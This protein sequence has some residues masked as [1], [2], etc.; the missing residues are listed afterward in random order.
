MPVFRE[1]S[2]LLASFRRGDPATLAVVYRAYSAPVERYLNGLAR[3]LSY[4][5]C[6]AS[7]ADVHQ[8]TF[9]RAFSP[10]ARAAYDATREFGPYLLTIAHNC[11]VS[12]VRHGRRELLSDELNLLESLEAPPAQESPRDPRV[13]ELL[14]AYVRGLP[15]PL[16][17]TFE[18]RFVF[19]HSQVV[20]STELGVTRRSFRTREAHLKRGLRRALQA[21]GLLRGD[22]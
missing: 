2:E 3:G 8:D 19:G 1:C 9:E 4:I 15:A 14:D 12:A 20:A 22:W 17:S 21:E 18:Q 13:T 6:L 16:R 11:F 7:T 5:P 10:R